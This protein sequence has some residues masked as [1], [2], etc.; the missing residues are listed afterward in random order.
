MT[1]AE[2]LFVIKKFVFFLYEIKIDIS[3]GRIRIRNLKLENRNKNT[4]ELFN[5]L[6]NRLENWNKR[7]VERRRRKNNIVVFFFL[8]FLSI[9]YKIKIK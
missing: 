2:T 6:F 1:I 7:N 8:L 3:V 9:E 4:F 5:I